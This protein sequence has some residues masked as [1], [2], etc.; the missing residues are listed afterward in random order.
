[1]CKNNKH[2]PLELAPKDVPN[3]RLTTA[4][5][6]VSQNTSRRSTSAPWSDHKTNADTSSALSDFNFFMRNKNIHR[7]NLCPQMSRIKLANRAALGSQDASQRYTNAPQSDNKVNVYDTSS[8]P[9]DINSCT[10]INHIQHS[11]LLPKTSRRRISKRASLSFHC[12]RST[13]AP[14]GERMVK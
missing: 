10:R 11:N 6:W 13:R 3:Y 1:V 7:T 4:P 5:L 12:Q 14:H 2:A 9:S 8:A